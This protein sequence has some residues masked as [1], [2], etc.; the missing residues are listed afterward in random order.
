MRFGPDGAFLGAYPFGWDTTPAIYAHD[1]TYSVVLKD[2]RYGDVGSYCNRSTVCPSDRTASH[3][4]S[5]E[6]YFLTQLSPDLAPEWSWRNAND[7]SCIR[8]GSGQV[9][10][11]ADHPAG[12]E[13]CV[14]AVAIDS[15]GVVYANSEDGNVYA[16]E[17]GGTLR[18]HLF[19]DRALG[20]AYTPFV[21]GGD[22]KLYAQNAGHLLV[23]GGCRPG[24]HRGCR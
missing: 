24:P 21:L 4:A 9:T 13:W 20:A 12:F 5:P 22:G 1:G 15:R 16:V 17:Q 18:D 19:L 3:P 23:V 11:V 8:R 2:N 14:N 10:C 6:G 7:L